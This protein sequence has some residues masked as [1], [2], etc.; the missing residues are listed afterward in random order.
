VGSFSLYHGGNEVT[1]KGH[2]VATNHEE[3]ILEGFDSLTKHQMVTPD[4]VQAEL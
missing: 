2:T 1:I 4:L 3:G